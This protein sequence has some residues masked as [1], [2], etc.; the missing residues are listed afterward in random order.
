MRVTRSFPKL[1]VLLGVVCIALVV[2]STSGDAG[3]STAILL[4][5]VAV[6]AVIAGIDVLW[7]RM[8]Q[9]FGIASVT[10]RRLSGVL[11]QVGVFLIAIGQLEPPSGV[12]FA[13]ISA[14]TEAALCV[15]RWQRQEDE[16]PRP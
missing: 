6:G 5:G 12:L 3:R 9:R 15:P 10:V 7:D 14:V 1:I 16:N 8:A 13:F 4:G 2:V 11:A